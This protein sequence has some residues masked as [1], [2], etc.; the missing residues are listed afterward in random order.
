[1]A[2]VAVRSAMTGDKEMLRKLTKVAGDQGMRKQARQAVTEVGQSKV[3]VMKTRTP[4]KTG[5]LLR[6]ERIKVLVSPK[7]EDIRLA[8]IAGGPDALHARKV[9]E[10]HPTHAKFMERTLHEA[11]STIAAEI[12]AKIDLK[13]AAGA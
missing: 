12:G 3:E 8:L 9:H 6:S 1:M 2:R 7:K 10:T 5:R 4:V 13:Q 11:A